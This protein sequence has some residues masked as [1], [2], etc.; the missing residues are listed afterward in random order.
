MAE[1]PLD[2]T[3]ERSGTLSDGKTVHTSPVLPVDAKP[4]P[5]AGGRALD[6]GMDFSLFFENNTSRNHAGESQHGFLREAVRFAEAHGFCAIWLPQR[7]FNAPQG[8]GESTVN[9]VAADSERLAVRTVS[10]SL[11]NGST[12][13][14]TPVWIAIHDDSE[15][16][17]AAARAG[18]YVL[19]YL[20]GR[21]ID[22]LA[23]DIAL[24]R[25]TWAE[26]G[27]AGQGY[28]TVVAP[29]LVSNGEAVVNRAV[30]EAMQAYLRQK[31]ALLREAAW[32]FPRFARAAED[33]GITIDQFLST[34]SNS[35]FDELLQFSVERYIA[36][37][38]LIGAAPLS[39][40]GRAT[41]TNRGG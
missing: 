26:S 18:A 20:L 35:E 16:F 9:E 31:I 39:G 7:A 19:T 15:G 14:G 23:K 13:P 8:D 37:G 24:Y 2:S 11:P 38:S 10:P 36:S 25:R 34:Q 40:T 6:F 41:E 5:S 1:G 28:V 27:R 4:S 21:S 30:R 22:S 29:T 17:R 3:G 32:D 12:G 33:D